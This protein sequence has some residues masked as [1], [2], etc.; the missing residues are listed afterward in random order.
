M[1]ALTMC[2]AVVLCVCWAAFAS[3]AE[4]VTVHFP[5]PVVVGETT[6]PA[7]NVSIEIHRGSPNVML[8]FRSE[9]G[10]TSTL[11]ASRITDVTLDHPDTQVILTH[12]GNT[13]KVDRIWFGDHNGLALAQ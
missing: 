2:C 11:M 7:G 4:L 5:N 3:P 9:S 6:L 13:F 10:V 1:K 12:E 8:T